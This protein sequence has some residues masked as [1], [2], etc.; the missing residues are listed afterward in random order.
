MV[1]FNANNSCVQTIMRYNA[2]YANQIKKHN[3]TRVTLYEYHKTVRTLS[4]R[5]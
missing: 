2:R 3:L 5:E 4:L 1:G